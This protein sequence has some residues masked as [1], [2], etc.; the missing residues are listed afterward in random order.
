[1]NLKINLDRIRQTIILKI[2]VQTNQTVYYYYYLRAR[3]QL[4]QT[5][6]VVDALIRYLD[7]VN[8]RTI[9]IIDLYV[10]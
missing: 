1:M 3:R 10:Q 7:L 6:R 5:L 4:P 8:N 2:Y 9:C